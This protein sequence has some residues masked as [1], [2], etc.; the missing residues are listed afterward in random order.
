ME[1]Y[2]KYYDVMLV[3]SQEFA[4]EVRIVAADGR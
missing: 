1:G 2:N 3:E 4:N